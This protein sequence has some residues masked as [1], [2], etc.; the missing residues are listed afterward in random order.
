MLY[1][2]NKLCGAH[3]LSELILFYICLILLSLKGSISL[4]ILNGERV[5][6]AQRMRHNSKTGKYSRNQH[7]LIIK[8][9]MV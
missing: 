4:I 2:L 5:S 8:I 6:P 9:N 1:F 3:P 7:E